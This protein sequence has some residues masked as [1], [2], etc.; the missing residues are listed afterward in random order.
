[1][2]RQGFYHHLY[3]SQFKGNLHKG[4]EKT[5]VAPKG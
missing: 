2:D 5:G 3:I 4:I 1:M